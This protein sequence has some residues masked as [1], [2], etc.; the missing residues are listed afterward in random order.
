M[1]LKYL[2]WLIPWRK[3]TCLIY[4]VDRVLCILL[5]LSKYKA[6]MV[7]YIFIKNI[8]FLL[9]IIKFVPPFLQISTFNNFEPF[10]FFD[11]I[12]FKIRVIFLNQY[13]KLHKNIVIH[14]W[15]TI[16]IDVIY[17]ILARKIYWCLECACNRVRK[18]TFVKR[19]KPI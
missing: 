17:K 5:M 1:Y 18:V 16:F 12:L 14:M 19:T 2:H 11:N 10:S 3:W 8:Q 13:T 6:R 7:N 4:V 9:W 15:C